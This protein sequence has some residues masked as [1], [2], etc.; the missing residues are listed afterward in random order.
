MAKPAV[1]NAPVGQTLILAAQEAG[2][3]VSVDW[4]ATWEHGFS[5]LTEETFL[6]RGRTL[7][8]LVDAVGTKYGLE[9]AWLSS[10]HILLTNVQRLHHME[11]LV[12]LEMP[13]PQDLESLKRKLSRFSTLS[14]ND[15]PSIRF[16]IDPQTDMLLAIIRPLRTVEISQRP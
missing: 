8:G 6:P 12:H 1:K 2:A 11:M 5:P 7:Q 15:L 4:P 16:A 14:E 9:V 10:N 3:I 13:T